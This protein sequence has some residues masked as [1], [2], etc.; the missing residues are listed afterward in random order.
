MKLKHLYLMLFLSFTFAACNKNDKN[1]Q[2]FDYGTIEE[3]IYHNSYF[4]FS[5]AVPSGWATLSQKQNQNLMNKNSSNI[6]DASKITTVILLTASQ[7][8]LGATDSVFNSN[9]LLLAENV[10]GNTRIRSGA[11]YLKL[12]RQ[13]L[14]KEPVK[15]EYPDKLM[16]AKLIN[17][18][19]FTTMRVITTDD[20][21]TYSQEY[22]TMLV[23]DFALTAILTYATENERA[24]LEN[25][26][27]TIKFI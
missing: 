12:T 25:A 13:A 5:V 24:I 8:E 14:E 15:R 11:D 9:M 2:D 4:N 23:D 1:R 22:Y 18:T 6:S 16:S 19:E 3:G 21:R 20:N 26:L 7:F 27:S 10:T 17:G